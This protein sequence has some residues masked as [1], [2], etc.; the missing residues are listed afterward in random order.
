MNPA[1]TETDFSKLPESLRRSILA[2]LQTCANERL[3]VRCEVI[4]N[5][6][7]TVVIGRGYSSPKFWIDEF[8]RIKT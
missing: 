5:R 7:I 6:D 2:V 4:G 3:S 8:Q 1:A